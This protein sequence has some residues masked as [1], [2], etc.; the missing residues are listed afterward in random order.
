M[1]TRVRFGI[2]LSSSIRDQNHIK[3]INETWKVQNIIQEVNDNAKDECIK[4]EYKIDI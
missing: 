2:L 3:S 1:H 4:N